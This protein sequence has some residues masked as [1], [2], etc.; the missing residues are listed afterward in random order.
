MPPQFCATAQIEA[1]GKRRGLDPASAMR[2]LL[3]HDVW[4]ER[5]RRNYGV[6]SASLQARLIELPILIAGCGGLGGEI[7]ASLARL[8]AG[9]LF[10]CDYD[11]FEESN[12]NRQHF[13]TEKSLG[14]A[15]AEVC[16]DALLQIAP[17]GDFRPLTQKLTPETL[18]KLLP[19]CEIVIDCLDSVSAKKML[20]Q[21]AMKAAK[22]W[23]HGSVSQHEGFACLQSSPDGLISRLYAQEFREPA[24]YAVLSHV[25]TGTAALM[26]S[27]FLRWLANP[28]FSSSLLHIDFSVPELEQFQTE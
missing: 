10:L 7:A 9:R 4:P 1:W 19:D 12:L 28:A 14:K 18:P 6:L 16:A 24:P 25:V 8:G 15:K 22:P 13:C 23:L 2:D 3:G 17:Y 20:E 27:L 26:A 11:R 5:F 21:A